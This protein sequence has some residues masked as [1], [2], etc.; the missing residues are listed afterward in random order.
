MDNSICAPTCGWSVSPVDWTWS[1][2]G[3]AASRRCSSPSSCVSSQGPLLLRHMSLD[4]FKSS[5]HMHHSNTGK[6]GGHLMYRDF[7]GCHWT[8]RGG[9]W[10][11]TSQN[12][13]KPLADNLEPK[14]V[15]E[16]VRL[17]YMH[18]SLFS[19]AI[20]PPGCCKN[21]MSWHHMICQSEQDT[22][23]L[24]KATSVRV[25]KLPCQVLW[26]KTQLPLC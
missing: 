13:G 26:K 16:P 11:M 24:A 14:T 20:F 3:S 10:M 22:V 5:D 23:L 18:S 4:S 15:K 9:G 19:P 1:L 2:L 17:H 7:T 12:D 6:C 25:P 21:V 8:S